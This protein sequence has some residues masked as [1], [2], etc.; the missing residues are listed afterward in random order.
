MPRATRSR[1]ERGTYP[2]GQWSRRRAHAMV[3][4]CV[5]RSLQPTRTFPREK[6]TMHKLIATAS[7]LVVLA[8][9]RAR[10]TSS[11]TP[12]APSPSRRSLRTSSPS[13]AS[14]S[15]RTANL[16]YE[17]QFIPGVPQFPGFVNYNVDVP[18]IALQVG[19]ANVSAT[20]GM[21]T[22]LLQN[23]QPRRHG[24]TALP[25]RARDGRIHAG[26][27]LRGSATSSARTTSPR[28]SALGRRRR[29][30]RTTGTSRAA[31]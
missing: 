7:A 4:T 25:H 29:G 14:Q 17:V 6:A 30:A 10:V 26:H 15:D 8:P 1:S 27:G 11:S 31:E 20:G 28:I 21:P 23:R 13:R 24:R 19:P 9:L 3:S 5:S 18:T 12:P 22:I 16:T 2:K